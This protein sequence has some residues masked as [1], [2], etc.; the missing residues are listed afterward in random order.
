MHTTIYFNSCIFYSLWAKNSSEILLLK[1]LINNSLIIT[2]YY[3]FEL[4]QQWQKISLGLFYL[5]PA[6]NE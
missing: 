1:Y 5:P 3:D 6:L 2:F 4:L